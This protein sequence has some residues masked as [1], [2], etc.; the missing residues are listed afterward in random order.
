MTSFLLLVTLAAPG[1]ALPVAWADDPP[2]AWA[3]EPPV[4]RGCRV[5][6]EQC[7][8]GCKAGGPCR[9]VT[10]RHAAP[11]A[12]VIPMPACGT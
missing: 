2:R 4:R 9:C 11:P 7:A 8:C 6:S 10:W 1:A 12:V 5:C 3:E